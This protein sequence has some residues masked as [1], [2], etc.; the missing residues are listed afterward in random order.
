MPGFVFS[1]AGASHN[2]SAGKGA[3]PQVLDRSVSIDRGRNPRPGTGLAQADD[4]PRLDRDTS[5]SRSRSRVRVLHKPSMVCDRSIISARIGTAPIPM[6]RAARS[7]VSA[8][9]AAVGGWN[10]HRRR[11]GEG[12]NRHGLKLRGCPR[13]DCGANDKRKSKA[14]LSSAPSFDSVNVIRLRR[15]LFHRCVDACTTF[16]MQ[17]RWHV[18]DLAKKRSGATHSREACAPTALGRPGRQGKR[19]SSVVSQGS[20]MA[21]QGRSHRDAPQRTSKPI[22]L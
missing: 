3:G 2:A 22:E 14:V 10:D 8:S 9:A 21:A 15:T 20:V 4:R 12:L 13:R 7:A 17:N 6:A 1:N 19:A 5:H 18:L 16:L 11:L